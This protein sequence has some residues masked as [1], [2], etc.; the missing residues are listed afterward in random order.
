MVSFK[1]LLL[2]LFEWAAVVA[3]AGIG[4]ALYAWYAPARVSSPGQ[5]A[6]I[7][8]PQ[9]MRYSAAGKAV[10]AWS[11]QQQQALH[12]AAVAKLKEFKQKQTELENSRTSLSAAD[13]A[14]K[15]Q[16][17]QQQVK[18]WNRQQQQRQAGVNKAIVA[19]IQGI[20]AAVKDQLSLLAR[21]EG[22]DAVLPAQQA[23]F[24]QPKLDLT[25]QLLRRLDQKLTKNDIYFLNQK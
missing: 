4:A 15:S 24:V 13:F 22:F 20:R 16:D 10:T 12:D 14:A 17:L 6:V 3:V 19:A 1:R 25:P 7:D 2:L 5:I 9:V 18:D 11:N 23:F 21:D 8:F